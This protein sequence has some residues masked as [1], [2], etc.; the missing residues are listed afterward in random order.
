MVA[1]SDYWN[2]ERQIRK[3]LEVSMASNDPQREAKVEAKMKRDP[4]FVLLTLSCRGDGDTRHDRGPT[5][6]AR[7]KYADVPMKPGEYRITPRSKK[8]PG[9]FNASINTRARGV[10]RPTGGT[11]RISQFD[12]TGIKGTFDF[13]ATAATFGAKKAKARSITVRGR[14]DIP[15]AASGGDRCE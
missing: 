15:C 13:E 10:W 4:R 14:F 5:L 8:E 12:R 7:G 6:S 11:V 2:S 9:T 3:A 1:G